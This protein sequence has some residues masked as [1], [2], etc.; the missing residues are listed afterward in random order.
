MHGLTPR[1]AAR[2]PSFPAKRVIYLKYSR[3][4][5]LDEGQLAARTAQMAESV[6]F[7]VPAEDSAVGVQ[8]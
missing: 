1:L 2:R 3:G 8:V 6:I 7:D 5:G 4:D